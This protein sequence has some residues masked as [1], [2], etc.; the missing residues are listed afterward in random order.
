[1]TRCQRC[2]GTDFYERRSTTNRNGWRYCY[3]RRECRACTK[4]RRHRRF[5]TI[6][7]DQDR[8]AARLARKRQ[9]AY[10]RGDWRAPEDRIAHKI[11]KSVFVE[12]LAAWTTAA[13]LHA[14]GAEP[15]VRKGRRARFPVPVDVAAE[16]ERA[17]YRYK[18]EHY[19]EFRERE[20]LRQRRYK[21]VNPLAG[22]STDD[23][24][25]RRMA[26]QA[27]GTLTARVVRELFASVRD[28]PYCG[29]G[30]KGGAHTLDHLD[31]LAKGG[32]HGLS[33]VLVVCK[34]CNRTK[35]DRLWE[36]WV[37]TLAEPY[38]SR[39]AR[40]YT[41]M[42]AGENALLVFQGPRPRPSPA[43]RAKR[44]AESKR[45][46]AENIARM[47]TP[48][49]KAKCIEWRA[50]AEREGRASWQTAA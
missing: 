47:R 7:A 21:A 18:Y 44:E 41:E 2:G 11:R 36:E 29:A 31:P 16:G 17:R 1:M 32:L 37:G 15:G 25:K 48:E 28:C 39:M 9:L 3:Q 14:N 6:K 10:E 22:L 26:E 24:R 19:P 42:K 38:R 13:G 4:E 49:W 43:D 33:N 27:D 12:M 46:Q 45:K 40:R 8:Y 5:A 34:P 30:L 35:R 50:K 20:R 23:N